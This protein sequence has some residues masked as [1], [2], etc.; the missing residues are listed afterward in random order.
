MTDFR[1]ALDE[2]IDAAWQNER[3]S[4]QAAEVLQMYDAL[5]AAKQEQPT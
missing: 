2:L 1:S 4:M 5:R 3:T